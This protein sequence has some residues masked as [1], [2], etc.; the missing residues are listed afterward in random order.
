MIIK[1]KYNNLAIIRYIQ[2]T[3]KSDTGTSLVTSYVHL[4]KDLI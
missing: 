2:H 4:I 1:N 3:R